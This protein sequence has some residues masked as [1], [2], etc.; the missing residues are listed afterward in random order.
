MESFANIGRELGCTRSN[1]NQTVKRALEKL[2]KNMKK[3]GITEGPYD[4]FEILATVFD[5]QSQK[6]VN[7]LYKSF[8]QWIQEEIKKDVGNPANM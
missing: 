2:Y 3:Q 7:K 4:T 1:I 6:D 5:L 8:P